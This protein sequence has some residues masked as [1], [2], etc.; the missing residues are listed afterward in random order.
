MALQIPETVLV[1]LLL[2]ALVAQRIEQRFPVPRVGG[3]SP[4]RCVIDTA[5]LADHKFRH[6]L[7]GAYG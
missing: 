6:D 1:F 5:I 2:N 3:S 7:E 4:F